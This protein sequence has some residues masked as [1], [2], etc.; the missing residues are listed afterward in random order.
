MKYHKQFVASTS[1]FEFGQ[2][3]RSIQIVSVF[4]FQ[5][6]YRSCLIREVLHHL[7]AQFIHWRRI[8]F[9]RQCR[10]RVVRKTRRLRSSDCC[11]VSA[12]PWLARIVRSTRPGSLVFPSI[13]WDFRWAEGSA[14]SKTVKPP[15]RT[16]PGRLQR[17]PIHS[18]QSN[19]DQ[20]D[21]TICNLP[22]HI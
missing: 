5:A 8:A 11:C 15:P 22:E 16:R 21:C 10:A 20:N 3:L 19:R 1:R 9:A 6:S 17:R 13:Y 7:D 12:G 4:V 2:I 18:V 14:F